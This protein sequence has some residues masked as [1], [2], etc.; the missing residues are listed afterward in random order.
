M[1]LIAEEEGGL[2]LVSKANKFIE[3]KVLDKNWDDFDWTDS[4]NVSE[5]HTKNQMLQICY[6]GIESIL[7]FS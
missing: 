7:V 6:A 4:L 1:L 2:E 3:D 5:Y